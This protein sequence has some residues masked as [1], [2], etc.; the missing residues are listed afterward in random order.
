M[1]RASPVLRTVD[2]LLMSDVIRSAGL[3]AGF[4]RSNTVGA[5]QVPP[6]FPRV[7][8]SAFLA[9]SLCELPA[10][11]FLQTTQKTGD[12]MPLSPAFAEIRPGSFEH[13]GPPRFLRG[14][15]M[16]TATI[17]GRGLKN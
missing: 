12:G 10:S 1:H 16:L 6:A 11:G 15:P 3:H 7:R 4:G 8:S 14:I 9:S 5:G 13:A 2:F 17:P